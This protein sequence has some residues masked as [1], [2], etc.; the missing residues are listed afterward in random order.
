METPYF[1]IYKDAPIPKIVAGTFR[2][3]KKIGLGSFGNLFLSEDIK[4]KKLVALKIEPLDIYPSNHETEV[5]VYLIISGSIGFPKLYWHEMNKTY[6]GVDRET[7]V[8]TFALEDH[9]D[10]EFED[11]RL[12][13]DVYISIDKA[14]SQAK[15]MDAIMEKLTE[16]EK[17]VFMR[18]RNTHVN[19]I[20]KNATIGEYLE[21]TGFEAV[22]GYLYLTG[23]QERL[24][25][26]LS[27]D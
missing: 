16:E 12:L 15:K 7:D 5:T 6:R 18:A 27:I 4:T 1:N 24:E 25:E 14:K 13:G 8:I 23:Q 9:K 19:S 21:A 3:I 10:I 17:D 26:L 2:T 11:V 22:V 20:A